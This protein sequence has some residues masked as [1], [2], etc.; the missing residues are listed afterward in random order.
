MLPL[1]N[2]TAKEV[3]IL[4]MGKLKNGHSASQLI[5]FGPKCSAIIYNLFRLCAPSSPWHTCICVSTHT[6][7][8]IISVYN[9][10]CIYMSTFTYIPQHSQ[11]Q[12]SYTALIG[13]MKT[14][15]FFLHIKVSHHIHTHNYMHWHRELSWCLAVNMCTSIY[16]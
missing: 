8:Y 10:K 13:A 2:V 3:G 16:S 9:Q 7:R 11:P 6:H 5:K 1:H 12:L 4:C 14:P 15:Y